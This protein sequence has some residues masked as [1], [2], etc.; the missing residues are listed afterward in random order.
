MTVRASDFP[1]EDRL[2]LGD[3][4]Y[5]ILYAKVGTTVK[6]TKILM[7]NKIANVFVQTDKPLYTPGQQGTFLCIYLLLDFIRFIR[8]S[9]HH[10]NRFIVTKFLPL[11]KTMVARI[12]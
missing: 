8:F 4:K 9:L 11:V 12:L 7:S 3:Q 10:M 6:E 1:D 2:K 5:V